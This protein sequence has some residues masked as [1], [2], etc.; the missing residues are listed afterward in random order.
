MKKS[1]FWILFLGLILRLISL[2]QS[3]WL[4]EA[5]TAYVAGHFSFA[6]IITK[7]SPGDF[8]PPLY[9]LILRGWSMIFAISE[10]SVRIPSVVFGLLTVYLVF[11]I[12]K[13]LVN[14]KTG[15]V[16]AV[17]LA[18]S[19]L[20]I[21][22]SQEARMYALT[23]LLVSCLV[24]LFLK[25]KW[26]LFSTFLVLVA[27]TDYVALLVIPV[28]WIAGR[29]DW[30]KLVISHLPLIFFF[31]LWSPVFIRQLTSGLG[32]RGSNWWGILGKSSLKEILLIPVKFSF[33]RI[34]LDNK[35]LYT[36]VTGAVSGFYIYILSKA[37]KSSLLWL[38]F[39]FPA[40]T[41]VILGLWLPVLSYFR[42]LFILPVFY[43]LLAKGASKN[44]VFIMVILV[45]NLFSTAIYL[46]NP[47]FHRENWRGLVSFVN[48]ESINTNSLTLFVA[49]SN[50]EA[51]RYYDSSAKI[52]GPGGIKSGFDQIRLMRYV[53]PIF[54]PEDKA[55]FRIEDLGFKKMAEYDFNGVVVWRYVK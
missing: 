4:D 53:Q 13:E 12:G 11:L 26:V 46:F 47:R 1:L 54:D 50:M 5:T 8:H 21:Y 35:W 17:L 7:F 43:L 52:S 18:T 48:K 44:K 24:Y 41:A 40:I 31:L 23:A 36:L 9:Y 55:R 22:Y 3:L 34:S 2:N 10:V 16:A 19:G 20:H 51:Y 25:K 42:L 15:L 49:D 39:L 27:M 33:G 28:F 32:A 30:R 6:E 29:K 14:R 45:I 37:K 38:W